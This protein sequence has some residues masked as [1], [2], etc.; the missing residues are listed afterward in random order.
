MLPTGG[1]TSAARAVDVTRSIRSGLN[2][3]SDCLTLRS[4]DATPHLL[5]HTLGKGETM[6]RLDQYQSVE[7]SVGDIGVPHRFRIWH[8]DAESS[9]ILIKKDSSILPHLRVGTKLEMTYYSPGQAFPDGTR[10]TRIKEISEEEKGRFK[11]HFLVNLE[12]S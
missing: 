5:I 8:I 1:S 11:G 9:A 2:G 3:S 7:F 4:L 10:E 12:P 6:K